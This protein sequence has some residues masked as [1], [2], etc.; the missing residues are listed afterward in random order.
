MTVEQRIANLE[1][2]CRI[3][4][5]CLIGMVAIGGI[6]FL[7]GA[8][9]PD[10][11]DSLT[12]RELKIVDETGKVRIHLGGTKERDGNEYFFLAMT[13]KDGKQTVGLHDIAQ[14]RV[15][16]GDGWLSLSA[17]A[18][19]AR[20]YA[21]GPKNTP[22][23]LLGVDNEEARFR[24]TDRSGKEIHHLHTDRRAVKKDKSKSNPF[25]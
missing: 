8:A 17:G 1:R 21:S 24:L 9:A 11:P 25:E 19:G 6:A 2:R 20:L 3:L 15:R 7:L 18:G 13:D 12:A 16:K 23:V 4:M 14:I 5:S 22:D 10:A